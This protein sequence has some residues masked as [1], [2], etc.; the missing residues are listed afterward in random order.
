MRDIKELGYGKMDIQNYK[1]NGEMF[2]ANIVVYPIFDSPV[3]SGKD[4]DFPVLTHYA[5]II[6]P[7][8][9]PLDKNNHEIPQ[10]Q[11]P[12][13]GIEADRDNDESKDDLCKCDDVQKNDNDVQPVI[14]RQA[15]F[16]AKCVLS[17]EVRINCTISSY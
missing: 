17:C 1:K 6:I 11:Q 9:P 4:S 5:S 15:K 7:I 12:Q 10:V 2:H 8:S 13:P 3:N 14:I 16:D